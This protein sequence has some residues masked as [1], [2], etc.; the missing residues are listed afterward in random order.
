[1]NEL[2]WPAIWRAAVSVSIFLIP[3]GVLQRVLV[4][5]ETGGKATAGI[6]VIT[7]V[8]FV[9]GMVAGFGAAKLARE[10][11]LPNGA[12]AGA[13]AYLIAAFAAL[14]RVAVFGGG[15]LS[16]VGVAFSAITMATCG[17]FGAGLERRS[18]A[19]R[20]VVPRDDAPKPD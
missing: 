20:E 18:R 4:D 11:V 12:A 6:Y 14:V 17:M 3:I 13:L 10:H 19:L 2:R 5:R 1:V 9:L 8:I 16:V 15:G 7:F